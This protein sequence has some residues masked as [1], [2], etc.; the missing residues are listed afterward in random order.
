MTHMGLFFHEDPKHNRPSRSRDVS[1]SA[2]IPARCYCRPL[3]SNPLLQFP[4][5]ELHLSL[6]FPA[7]ALGM[8]RH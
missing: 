2:V 6:R 7:L 3:S 5:S 4:E 1:I 8:L